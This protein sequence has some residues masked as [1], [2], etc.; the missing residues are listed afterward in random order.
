VGN[1]EVVALYTQG[2]LTGG[3]LQAAIDDALGSISFDDIESSRLGIREEELR[4]VRFTVDEEGGFIA[5]AI[6][7]AIVAG[8][9]G[10]LTSDAVKAVWGKVLER[11]KDKHGDDAVGPQQPKQDPGS[12]S[13]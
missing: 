4:A 8:A 5:E 2:A 9:A 3:R 12:G 6:L 1:S 13:E 11:V 10:N 7:L